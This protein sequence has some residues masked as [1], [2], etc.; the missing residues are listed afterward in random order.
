MIQSCCALDIS[1]TV[2]GLTAGAIGTSFPN[3]YASVL[4]A[5]A[6]QGDQSIC[7]AFGSN[8]FNVLI[9]LG[10]VWLIQTAVGN[11]EFGVYTDSTVPGDQLWCAGCY[12][13]MGVAESC[14]FLMKY[15]PPKVS[16]SL[17]GTAICIYICIF[18]FVVSLVIGRGTI[19]TGAGVMFFVIYFVYVIYE[20]L[21]SYNV[22]E[23]LCLSPSLCL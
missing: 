9:C 16:G 22:F 21:T 23:P 19:Y 17:S 11:C 4:T 20:V 3:L 1:D 6:G 2:M 10:F 5:K 7:Q 18:A 15:D 8:T 13:P 12:K 14:P